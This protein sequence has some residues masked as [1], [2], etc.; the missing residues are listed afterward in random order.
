MV[1]S[2]VETLQNLTASAVDEQ[3]PYATRR[4]NLTA[5]TRMSKK[6]F[7]LTQQKQ[8]ELTAYFAAVK[9]N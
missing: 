9:E 8:S 4:V 2:F 6:C 3:S 7:P 5:G 1:V